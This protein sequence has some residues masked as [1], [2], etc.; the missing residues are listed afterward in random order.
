MNITDDDFPALFGLVAGCLHQDMDLAYD[1]V[2][3]A[4]A[5]Y[6]CFTEIDEKQ[7][8]FNEMKS[9]LERYNNDLDGEF[10]RRFGFNFT[11]ESIGL[12]VPEFF[13]M[14]RTIMDDPESYVR[15]KPRN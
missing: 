9:F 12:T 4:L 15:F 1:T 13:E 3:E 10:S 14:L 5:G 2:P 8:L 11:P 7:M 6:A